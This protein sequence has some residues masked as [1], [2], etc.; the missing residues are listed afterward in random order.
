MS[1][2]VCTIALP[3][4]G[5]KRISNVLELKLQVVVSF[6]MWVLETKFGV[7]GATSVFFFLVSHQ[8]SFKNY[9]S[10]LSQVKN[11]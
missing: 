8:I 6:L 7:S 9:S 2:Y 10:P 5:Q 3:K 1:I 4:G 11:I